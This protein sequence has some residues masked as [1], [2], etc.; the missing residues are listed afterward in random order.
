MTFPQ[1]CCW[2]I[3]SSGIW[4]CVGLQT[5]A[6]WSF[7]VSGTA[8]PAEQCHIQLHFNLHSLMFQ[9]YEKLLHTVYVTVYLDFAK[10]FRKWI[11]SCLMVKGGKFLTRYK[12]VYKVQGPSN[13]SEIV[14]CQYPVEFKTCITKKNILFKIYPMFNIS[15]WCMSQI[16]LKGGHW[17]ILTLGL[18]WLCISSLKFSP[19][20]VQH[21]KWFSHL[22]SLSHLPVTKSLFNWNIIKHATYFLGSDMCHRCQCPLVC[23]NRCTIT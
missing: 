21:L 7:L 1:Q 17:Q 3:Q 14:H 12:N 22:V 2:R 6:Q 9:L 18:L 16:R 19:L 10:L 13:P 5:E 15:E 20:A 4:C 23:S 8:Y 11:P